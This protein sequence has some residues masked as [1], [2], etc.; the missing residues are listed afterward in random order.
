MWWNSRKKI[1]SL[2]SALESKGLK[3]NLLK[4]KFMVGKI[5]Q[6]NIEPSSKK[7][8]CGICGRKSMEKA[9]LCKSCGHWKHGRHARI[10]RVT[11]K[12]GRH[13]SIKRVT[14]KHGRHA[15]IKRVTN[16]HGRHARIKRVTNKHGRH[17]RI[18]RV[19]NKHAIDVKC[20]KYNE[21]HKNI[22]DQNKT[23]HYDV[24]TV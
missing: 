11:N 20:R 18:K 19:T 15:R 22:E 23:L 7:D 24:E 2:K 16:K 12:H 4:T 5:G 1:H 10:K 9:A 13:A 6:I 8:P 21:C 17:A 3:V 14:N